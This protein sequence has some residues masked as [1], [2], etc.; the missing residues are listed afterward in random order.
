MF[1]NESNFSGVSLFIL[2]S[3]VFVGLA[4]VLLFVGLLFGL[5][6]DSLEYS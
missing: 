4:R 3:L 6:A 2:T 1:C 5:G